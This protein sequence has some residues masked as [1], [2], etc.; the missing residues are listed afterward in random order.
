M[1]QYGTGGVQGLVP[2]GISFQALGSF[3]KEKE[4]LHKCIVPIL[5]QHE[6]KS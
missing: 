3:R 6:A 5:G 1:S 4:S 2:K